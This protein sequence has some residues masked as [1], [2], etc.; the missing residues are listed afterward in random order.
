MKV[1]RLTAFLSIVLWVLLTARPSLAHIES[2]SM[3][4]PVAEMEYRILLEFKPNDIPTINKFGMVLYRLNKLKEATKE[5][6]KVL[7]LDPGNFNAL[8]AMGLIK[9]KQN[10]YDA[11]IKYHKA[12]IAIKKD[13][14]LVYYHLGKVLEKKGLWQE[15]LQAYRTA[16]GNCQIPQLAVATAVKKKQTVEMIQSAIAEVQTKL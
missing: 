14:V 10:E 12:A 4:D 11:A 7:Q 1:R 15:A 16:L 2:G 13:D 6:S 8:D 9:A 3:P 5:F